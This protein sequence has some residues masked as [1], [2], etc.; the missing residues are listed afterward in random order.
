MLWMTMAFSD[1]V[2]NRFLLATEGL[3]AIRE[4]EV[5]A[6]LDESLADGVRD[7]GRARLAGFLFGSCF[8]RIRIRDARFS[9]RA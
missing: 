5:I 4:V 7:S 6:D 8:Y 9:S 1:R 3:G 2:V